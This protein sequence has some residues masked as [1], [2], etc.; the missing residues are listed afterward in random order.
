MSSCR[1][2]RLQLLCACQSKMYARRYISLSCGSVKNGF[3]D[4]TKVQMGWNWPRKDVRCERQRKALKEGCREREVAWESVSSTEKINTK[5]NLA[6]AT[7]KPRA[8]CRQSLQ[9]VSVGFRGKQGSNEC[10][11]IR[12]HIG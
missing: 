8:G 5:E 1:S 6:R 4:P 11:D 2:L 10:L 9:D 3:S 7:A 12:D